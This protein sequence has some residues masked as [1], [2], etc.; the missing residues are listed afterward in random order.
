MSSKSATTY[1]FFLIDFKNFQ[2]L[3]LSGLSAKFLLFNQVTSW[4][5]TLKYG[6][7]LKACIQES[8]VKRKKK[9]RKITKHLKAIILMSA[10][11]HGIS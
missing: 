1:G 5:V 11:E 6:R 2:I 4:Q 7:W 9:K 3:L 8:N 10:N